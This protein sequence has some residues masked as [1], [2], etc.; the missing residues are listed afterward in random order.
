MA[1]GGAA[2]NAAWEICL[3]D[4]LTWSGRA[5]LTGIASV[6]VGYVDILHRNIGALAPDALSL[7][8]F[9][10]FLLVMT[11]G[12]AYAVFELNSL[13]KYVEPRLRRRVPPPRREDLLSDVNRTRRRIRLLYLPLVSAC[14]L[15]IV[16]GGFQTLYSRGAGQWAERSIEIIRP[17]VTESEHLRLRATLRQA[18]TAADF[19]SLEDSL[20]SLASKGG[21][22]LPAFASIRPSRAGGEPR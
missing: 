6:W 16:L 8:L 12:P 5:L 2:G 13:V 22:A 3:R 15:T 9:V 21:I 7:P 4:A 17:H 1:I 10:G 18:T 14:A 20:H 19:Y 11:M